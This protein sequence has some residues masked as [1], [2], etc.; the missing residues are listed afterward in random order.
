MKDD[1]GW[2]IMKKIVGLRGKTYS[3]LKDDHSEDKKAKDTKSVSYKANLNLK[4]IKTFQEQLNLRIKQFI[5]K[6]KHRQL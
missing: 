3:Y 6:K 2:N 1:L 5:S 4:I